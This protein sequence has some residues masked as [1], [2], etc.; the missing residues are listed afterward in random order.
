[1]ATYNVHAGHNPDGKVACG[2]V[3]LV[4][5]STEARFIKNEV[6]EKIRKIG[7]TVHDCTVDN[8]LNKGDIINK[9]VAKC[10]SNKVDLDI[11]IHFNAGAKDEKGNGRTTGVEVLCYNAA[12]T[13]AVAVGN[14]IC[15]AIESLGF[16]N[17]G[18]K[19]RTDLGVLKNTN[20]Q[21][22]LIEVCFVDDKD[23]VDLYSRNRD[24]ITTAIAEAITG[25]KIPITEFIPGHWYKPVVVTAD[26][27]N[28]RNLPGVN[29]T[30]VVGKLTK[31][32]EVTIWNITRTLDTAMWGS[33][34]YSFNPDIIG[35][36]NLAYA[37]PK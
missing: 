33:F 18:V 4:K 15:S 32:Q 2:A 34:R 16:R 8:G 26:S 31:G 17:R 12:S 21:A 6:I 28:V 9:I 35:Y 37:T 7:D 5:E 36:I 20:A 11:S 13:K 30:N 19:Y 1:M 14:K 3:G 29:G 24:K 25:K 22:L 10:N 23:D 27:L